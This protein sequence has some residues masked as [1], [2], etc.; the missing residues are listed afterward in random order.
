MIII[1]VGAGAVGVSIAKELIVNGHDVTLIDRAPEAIHVADVPEADWTLADACS[2]SA[3]EEAGARDC[4]AVVAATGDDKVNLIVSLLSKTEFA[5]PKVVARVNDPGNEWMFNSN[6]GV[7]VPTSTPRVMAA[8]VEESVTVGLAVRLFSIANAS[9]VIYTFVVP[10]DSPMLG[11]D[12]FGFEWPRGL[13]LSTIVRGGRPFLPS[14]VSD[15][16]AGDELLLLVGADDTAQTEA[17]ERIF[18]S[19]SEFPEE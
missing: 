4:D 15:F 17:M 7:D 18:A 6:W 13:L 1:V 9:V 11:I 14:N 19:P 3:L 8:L 10:Q 12:P 2:P 5:V 16:R